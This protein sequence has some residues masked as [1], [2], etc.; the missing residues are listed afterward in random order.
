MVNVNK[1]LI[2]A[3]FATVSLLCTLA[4]IVHASKREAGSQDNSE[5]SKKRQRILQDQELQDQEQEEL[6]RVLALSADEAKQKAQQEQEEILNALKLWDDKAKQKAQQEQEEYQRP[7]A[8]PMSS[9]QPA[10]QAPQGGWMS[11]LSPEA[12]SEALSVAAQAVTDFLLSKEPTNTFLTEN[13]HCDE[14]RLKQRLQQAKDSG[15][16]KLD[17]SDLRLIAIQNIHVLVP[18]GKRGKL[19]MLNLS[20]N[21]ITKLTFSVD[22]KELFNEESRPL[23]DITNCSDIL[24]EGNSAQFEENSAQVRAN[25]ATIDTLRARGYQIT[26]GANE[27]LIRFCLD[28]PECNKAIIGARITRVIMG[29]TEDLDLGNLGLV[30]LEKL[31]HKLYPGLERKIRMLNLSENKEL[32]ELHF[33]PEFKQLFSFRR[34]VIDVRNTG[35]FTGSDAQIRANIE[36]I[37]TLVE[38]GYTVETSIN[39]NALK[40][41]LDFCAQNPYCPNKI[42]V[43]A[44]LDQALTSARLNLSDLNLVN[45]EKIN[46]MSLPFMENKLS[47]IDLSNN[48]DL[49]TINFDELK[50]FFNN[51]E[52]KRSINISGTSLLEETNVRLRD[53]MNQIDELRNNGYHV[54][55]GV[56]EHLIKFHLANPACDKNL[57]RERLIQ[58]RDVKNYQELNL[59]NLGLVD[60]KTIDTHLFPEMHGKLKVLNLSENKELKE[61]HFSPAFK[62]LFDRDHKPL[63]I[64]LTGTSLL[65]EKNAQVYENMKK[66]HR[67]K[68]EGYEVITDT[69]IYELNL[70]L[71]NPACDRGQLR[72][73]IRKAREEKNCEELDLSGLNLVNELGFDLLFTNEE[74]KKLR[75]LN[76]ANNLLA[77]VEF[78][79]MMST[80]ETII[81]ADNKELKTI[82]TFNEAEVKNAFNDESKPFI[83][84]KNSALF[85]QN[86]DRIRECKNL[87]TIHRLKMRGY[88][89]QT[90]INKE[91]ECPICFGVKTCTIVTCCGERLCT[92]C[93]ETNPKRR[94]SL[95]DIALIEYLAGIGVPADPN[96]IRNSAPP[97][98]HRTCLECHLTECPL[99]RKENGKIVLLN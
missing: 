48:N 30:N 57:L 95:S 80:I 12:M 43:Q 83:D 66:I 58:S 68:Q 84:L 69:N 7:V 16:Q 85:G 67:L 34:L 74:I 38:D 1:R 70:F 52:E 77:E 39:R 47:S 71:N 2:V 79:P 35:L 75:T 49:T 31:D 88:T 27:Q 65:E 89:I 76:L 11:L 98:N 13:P 46:T 37:D 91:T 56:N 25:L 23:I 21:L 17:L 62:D 6:K 54:I 72:E 5:Q 73:R 78:T 42:I 4:D 10:T 3:T 93:C 32:K 87:Q 50:K 41:C 8:A 81:L 82:I 15:W 26:T 44:R 55:T 94:C 60:L 14:K 33:S 20:N 36:K 24:F 29:K 28:N 45:L 97:A 40:F 99:C 18:E 59:S 53:T 61:L 22:A 86:G 9:A 63:I 51:R 90:D 64:N 92:A 96:R 19:H